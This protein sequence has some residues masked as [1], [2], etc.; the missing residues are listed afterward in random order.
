MNNLKNLK[1]ELKK[2]TDK[3]PEK[4]YPTSVLENLG[5]NRS[6]CKKCKTKYWSVKKRTTCGEPECNDGYSFINNSPTKSKLSYIE[7]W[8]KY[9]KHM[10]KLGYTPI[11]RYPVVAR[12]RDDTWFTQASIYCFQPYVV[13]GQVKPPANPLVMSQPSLRFND[14]DNS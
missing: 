10:K 4:Y 1:L 7:T 3:N 8:K 5:F 14:I 9:S 11:K 6:T 2:K 13:S 12:W